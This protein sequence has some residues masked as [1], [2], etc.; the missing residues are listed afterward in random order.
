M[1]GRSKE[2]DSHLSYVEINKPRSLMCDH[3]AKV[4]A[5]EAMP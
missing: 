3:A 1:L 5:H 2:S 4:A